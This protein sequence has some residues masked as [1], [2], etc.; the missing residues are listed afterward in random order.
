M[1]SDNEGIPMTCPRCQSELEIREL[2]C[3]QCDLQIR[4]H[5]GH[6]SRFDQLSS[7]QYAF[8]EVFL[9]SRGILRDVESALGISYPTVRARLDNLLLAL[10][11]SDGSN[12]N[13]NKNE[14]LNK[15]APVP[16]PANALQAAPAPQ[17]GRRKEVL[18]ALE[19][20]E[21][22]VQ[23]ALEALRRIP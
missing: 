19:A 6:G 15:A 10:G 23:A 13:P 7:E 8:L 20:G 11:L 22:D 2:E 21:M 14:N 16:P 18:A 9:R 1:E 3:K 4:G 12:E 5:F 17:A